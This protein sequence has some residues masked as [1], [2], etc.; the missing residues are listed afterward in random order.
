F[1]EQLANASLL[2]G[3]DNEVEG[4]ILGGKRIA[5]AAGGAAHAQ[6][7]IQ[8]YRTAGCRSAT[9]ADDHRRSRQWREIAGDRAGAYPAGTAQE[10]A[11][12]VEGRGSAELSANFTREV[13]VRRDHPCFNF[14]LLRFA[15]ELADQ[16]I[17][18]WQNAG[19]ITDDE[20]VRTAVG[21]NIAAWREELLQRGDQV[22]GFRVAEDAGRGH[23]IRRFGLR[24]GQ[25]AVLL[26]LLLQGVLRCHA[27]NI[28]VQ[29]LIQAVVLKHDAQRLI[30]RYVVEDDGEVPLYRRIH[31]NVQA[32]DLMDQP[33]EVAQVNVLQVYRNRLAR[34][35]S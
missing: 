31:H 33:E 26:S 19:N 15:V 2:R 25:V 7:C 8:R 22:G 11:N 32:A 30:P 29:L 20:R 27:Q 35:L 13:P 34:V 10:A 5:D 18:D 28:S 3:G 16:V 17:E 12:A 23:H 6:V 24:L 14:H 9:C 1:R 21:Q 4:E